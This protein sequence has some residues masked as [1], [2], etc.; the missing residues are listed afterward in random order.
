MQSSAHAARA[1]PPFAVLPPSIWSSAGLAP[2]FWPRQMSPGFAGRL[3]QGCAGPIHEASMAT[4][5]AI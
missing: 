1:V 3:P 5:G 4:I 2:G